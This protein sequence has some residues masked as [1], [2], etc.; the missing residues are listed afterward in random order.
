MTAM[1]ARAVRSAIARSRSDAQ[2]LIC[3]TA[4]LSTTVTGAAGQRV[5]HAAPHSQRDSFRACTDA[6][7]CAR[8]RSTP[9][10]V[11]HPGV[12][13]PWCRRSHTRQRGPKRVP[14]HANS[15]PG[16]SGLI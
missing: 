6:C 2:A 9:W 13:S 4:C 10:R 3:W 12:R 1:A 14:T 11:D 5:A 15:T 8:E 7:R 16:S